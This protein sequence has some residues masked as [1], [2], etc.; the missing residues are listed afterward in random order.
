MNCRSNGIRSNGVRLKN[1][2]PVKW[3]FG[4]MVFGQTVFGQMV[5]RSKG[6]R[7][8]N[9]GEMIFRSSDPKMTATSDS[10]PLA[11]E[12]SAK[13]RK[14]RKMADLNGSSGSIADLKPKGPGFGSQIRQ[15]YICW[16]C[17]TKRSGCVHALFIIMNV[18]PCF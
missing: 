1:C 17:G 10:C 4:Q 11:S 6:V 12:N 13:E 7:S 3:P 8:K 2:V 14:G 9:F 16:W 5:F 18:S 15:G